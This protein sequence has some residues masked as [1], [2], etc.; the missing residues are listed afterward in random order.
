MTHVEWEKYLEPGG[1]ALR[2][3]WMVCNIERWSAWAQTGDNWSNVLNLHKARSLDHGCSRKL[4]LARIGYKYDLDQ[5]ENPITAEGE[6][7]LPELLSRVLRRTKNR[8]CV[9]KYRETMYVLSHTEFARLRVCN[10][11]YFFEI[12]PH[13]GGRFTLTCLGPADF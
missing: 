13:T 9:V 3:R 5:K 7:L 11:S 2:R 8:A 10:I 12:R 4:S 6:G 1:R